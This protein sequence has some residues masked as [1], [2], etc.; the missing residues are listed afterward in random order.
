LL[1]PLENKKY[2][3][4]TTEQLINR[5]NKYKNLR[6]ETVKHIA[7]ILEKMKINFFLEDTKHNKVK[8]GDKQY[9]QIN[10]LKSELK[11]KKDHLEV[12]F[13]PMKYIDPIKGKIIKADSRKLSEVKKGY[14]YFQEGDIL[15]AK[16]TP[17]MENGNV[18][19]A[20][21]LLNNIGFGSTE[22]HV[23]R[24][25]RG[26]IPEWIYFLF[27]T[28]RFRTIA[29]SYMT[30]TAGQQRV[31]KKFLEEY[32]LPLPDITIQRERV[33]QLNFLRKK[34][35]KIQELFT[36]IEKSTTNLTDNIFLKIVT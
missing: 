13:I 15:F 17:C 26:V 6:H 23:I 4:E 25:K 12:S 5:I 3:I 27:R 35:D 11:G 28:N 20:R 18:A 16:I 19:I 7:D 29:K 32:L 33:N 24:T 10:P 8:L 1:Y 14:T 2:I 36:D 30:G 22:F 9:F 21:N 34:L 31:P